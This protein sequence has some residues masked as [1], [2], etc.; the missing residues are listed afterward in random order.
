MKDYN[1]YRWFFTSS[2]TL[3]IGGKNASQNDSLL[4]QITNTNKNFIVMHTADPGSPFCII[5]KEVN[6]VSNKVISEAGIFTG[7]FSQAWKKG[8]KEVK[9]DIFRSIQLFKKKGM[10]AGTWTVI[11]K[12]KT[13]SV[14][15][16]LV[17]TKQ[18]KIYRA[19]PE[20]TVNKKDILLYL[21]PGKTDKE[22]KMNEI[23]QM[24]NEKDSKKN[25]LLAALPAG[26]ITFNK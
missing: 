23:I 3:V 11:G 18:N 1:S 22:K 20:K 15:L 26:G 4:K 8:Q 16:K 12:V 25:E 24:L 10:K 5:L 2:S 7:C 9:V 13:I 21:L 17:L 14:P 6:L 19:V